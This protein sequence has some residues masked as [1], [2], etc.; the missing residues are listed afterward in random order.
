MKKIILFIAISLDG[1]I[2]DCNGQVDWLN[3]QDPVV[4]SNSSYNKFIRTIDTV[5][6]GWNTYHQIVTELSPDQWIYSGMSSYVVTH[7]KF[8]STNEIQFVNENPCDL[9]TRL[10]QQKGKNIWIC[11]GANLAQQLI[12]ENLIDQFYISMIPTLLGKG[13]PLFGQMEQEL[14][15]KLIK[16]QTNNGI[17]D[18]VYERR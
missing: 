6:L 9:V 3:G 7:K 10:K 2:A 4:T 14:P 1:Y 12:R 18:L 11:G 8:T 15:L 13:I 16:T 17:T 5:V